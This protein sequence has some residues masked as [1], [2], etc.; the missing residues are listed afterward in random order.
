MHFINLHCLQGGA[1]EPEVR[2]FPQ[3]PAYQA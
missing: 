2:G 1:D 3:I